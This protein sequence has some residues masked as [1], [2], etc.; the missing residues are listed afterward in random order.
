MCR[1]QTEFQVVFFSAEASAICERAPCPARSRAARV[2][3]PPVCPGT[4]G[5][6]CS[7]LHNAMGGVPCRKLF[8]W[9]LRS[10]VRNHKAVAVANKTLP[11]FHSWT[12][13]VTTPHYSGSKCCWKPSHWVCPLK[14]IKHTPLRLPGTSV[15]V[16]NKHVSLGRAGW[17]TSLWIYI[18]LYYTMDIGNPSTAP[19]FCLPLVALLYKFNFFQ[20]WIGHPGGKEGKEPRYWLKSQITLFS[21]TVRKALC[22][23]H[24]RSKRKERTFI[25]T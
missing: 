14:A 17:K 6:L 21:Q 23:L 20:V 1:G 10:K 19:G 8:A 11:V 16:L 4:G 13:L 24:L 12:D 7:S 22:P 5:A 25:F 2:P 15:Q 3:S 9:G 18:L